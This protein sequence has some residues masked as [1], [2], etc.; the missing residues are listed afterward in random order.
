MRVDLSHTA[1]TD[2]D[3]RRWRHEQICFRLTASKSVS[4]ITLTCPRHGGKGYCAFPSCLTPAIMLTSMRTNS[5]QLL[6]QKWN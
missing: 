6:G 5:T 3:K 4:M 2:V 1:T